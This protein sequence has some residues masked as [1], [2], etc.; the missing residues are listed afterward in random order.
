MPDTLPSES[1]TDMFDLAGDYVFGTLDARARTVVM[2]LRASDPSFDGLVRD[3]ER[4]FAPLLLQVPEI[5]PPTALKDKVLRQ[6]LD[7]GDE[8]HT[9]RVQLREADNMSRLRQAIAVWRFVAVASILA[10]LGLLTALV[11]ARMAVPDLNA[12]VYVSVL[13]PYEPGKDDLAPA[14]AA[15][16][17]LGRNELRVERVGI[18][19]PAEKTYE[20]WAVGGAH[21]APVTL[22][23]VTSGLRVP[24]SKLGGADYLMLSEMQLVISLEP[25]GGSQTG[26]PT[27]PIAYIGKLFATSR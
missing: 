8:T 24:L 18:G 16:L 4:Q 2:E 21:H 13:T 22:G 19:P 23:L 3:L 14:F 9:R 25:P 26:Q 11:L 27:G 7:L 17:D 5:E 20:L 10:V 15:S 6:I 12:P 1:Q